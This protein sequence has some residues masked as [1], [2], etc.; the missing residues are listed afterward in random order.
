MT[1]TTCRECEGLG[2][3]EYV[4]CWHGGNCPCGGYA[5]KE[6]CESCEGTGRRCPDCC[7]PI[8]KYAS[9][10]IQRCGDCQDAVDEYEREQMESYNE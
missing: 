5:V 4:A 8:W 6:E 10:D 3:H 2:T 1:P 7:F 9:R